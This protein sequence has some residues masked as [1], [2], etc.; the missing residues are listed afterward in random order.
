MD[1]LWQAQLSESI[2]TAGQETKNGANSSMLAEKIHPKASDMRDFIGE[3]KITARLENL[4]L[5]FGEHGEQCRFIP[6]MAVVF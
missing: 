4:P 3:I 1:Y 6:L 2:Q 5:A